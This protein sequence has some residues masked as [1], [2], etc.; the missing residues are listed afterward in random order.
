MKKG[1]SQKGHGQ[2]SGNGKE[3]LIEFSGKED[4][5]KKNPKKLY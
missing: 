4:R 2:K 5:S 1:S 3:M